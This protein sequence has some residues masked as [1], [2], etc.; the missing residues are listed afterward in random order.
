MFSHSRQESPSLVLAIAVGKRL[1]I[2][3]WCQNAFKK[4]TVSLQFVYFTDI[5]WFLSSRVAPTKN[6]PKYEKLSSDCYSTEFAHQT[7]FCKKKKGAWLLTPKVN[8]YADFFDKQH[9]LVIQIYF[10]I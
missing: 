4:H 2:F 6:C 10:I 7:R 8:M 5:S 9:K 3:K 1:T